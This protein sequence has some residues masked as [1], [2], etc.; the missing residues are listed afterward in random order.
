MKR[1]DVLLAALA[2]PDP[3][4]AFEPVH[5]QKVM[6]LIDDRAQPVF[7]AG[8]RYQ[9]EPYDYGPFDSSVYEDL[10][11]LARNNLVVIDRNPEHGYRRYAATETGRARGLKMLSQMNPKHRDV[12]RDSVN[13]VLPLSFRSL[14]TAIY[15][16]YPEMKEKSVFK[17]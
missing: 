9:F 2:L 14:V 8:S 5:V 7:D 12:V 4:K 11:A 16:Q 6:F 3:P 10:D 1:Q 15:R 17:S 13:F